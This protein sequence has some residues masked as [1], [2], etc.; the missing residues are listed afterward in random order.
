MMVLAQ[1]AAKNAHVQGRISSMTAEQYR[2][3]W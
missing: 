2:P 1:A 3:L